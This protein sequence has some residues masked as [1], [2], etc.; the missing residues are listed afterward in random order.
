[1]G[2]GATLQEIDTGANACSVEWC[3]IAGL[4]SYVACSTYLLAAGE[5]DDDT[6]QA[7]SK[8]HVADD[9]AFAVVGTCS[10]TGAASDGEEVAA[11]E[12]DAGAGQKRSGSVVIHRL[13][14]DSPPPPAAAATASDE[15]SPA[16]YLEEAATAQLDGGVL[17][18]KW[19]THPADDGAAVLACVSSTGRL[20]LYSLSS[21]AEDVVGE[22]VELRQVAS[23]DV[24]DS[25]L[26]SLDWSRGTVSS[27]KIVVSQSDG[28]LAIWRLNPAG[29]AP[30]QAVGPWHAHSLRGGIP[31]EAWIS[32]F[33]RGSGDEDGSFV[34]SGAD[35]GLMK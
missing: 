11:A 15:T 6:E 22:R 5:Q 14:R 8:S 23:S 24:D 34:V 19:S 30:V 29:G 7:G 16:G 21:G 2:D 12:K 26:L 28:R 25:L 32:F 17:D 4:E 10:S 35:D 31:T 13:V 3:P 9:T 27:A 20:V 18:A 1:M 33:R